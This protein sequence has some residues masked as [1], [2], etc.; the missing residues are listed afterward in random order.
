MK[1]QPA[2]LSVA[3]MA[4]ALVALLGMRGSVAEAATAALTLDPETGLPAG[5]LVFRVEDHTCVVL[6]A[7]EMEC[8]CPCTSEV[9]NAQVEVVPSRPRA[10]GTDTVSETSTVPTVGGIPLWDPAPEADPEAE[11]EPGPGGG[12]D[13][14]RGN[15]GLGNGEDPAPPGIAK[16][17]KPQNDDPA[18]PGNPQYQGKGSDGQPNGRNNRNN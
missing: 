10:I 6:P 16:Q 14:P 7:R 8:F 3:G 15:N 12:D 18:E 1:K 13:R 9:C 2:V 4:I 5:T 11:Q 17:G